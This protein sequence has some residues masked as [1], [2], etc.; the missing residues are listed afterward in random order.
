MESMALRKEEQAPAAAAGQRP[1]LK[2]V[3]PLT[4]IQRPA[5]PHAHRTMISA[6][7]NGLDPELALV[8]YFGACGGM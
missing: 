3:P 8:M 1:H 5:N 6:I 4:E 7:D 2:E